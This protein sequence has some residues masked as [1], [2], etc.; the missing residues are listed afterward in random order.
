VGV[1]VVLSEAE[2]EDVA[3]ENSAHLSAQLKLRGYILGEAEAAQP[4]GRATA[5]RRSG[6]G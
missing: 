5:E 6:R 4:D 2:H 1:G 3:A